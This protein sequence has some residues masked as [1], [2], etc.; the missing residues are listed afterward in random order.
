MQQNDWEDEAVSNP[1]KEVVDKV[2]WP[3]NLKNLGSEE[4]CFWNSLYWKK[5]INK[6]VTVYPKAEEK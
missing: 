5:K 4:S 1:F 3:E 6:K 2:S